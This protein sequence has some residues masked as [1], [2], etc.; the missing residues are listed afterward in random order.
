MRRTIF[1]LLVLILLAPLFFSAVKIDL[2][3]N[4]DRPLG[5]A[6][7]EPKKPAISI[8]NIFNG[9]FQNEFEKYFNYNLRGRAT[10]SR[11]Y[12]QIIYGLFKSTT[13]NILLT[14]KDGYLFEAG[15][16]LTYLD[17][18]AENQKQNL[19]DKMVTLA[20]LQKT[21]ERMGKYL[22]VIITPSKAS[23]YPEHLPNDYHKYAMLKNGGGGGIHKI[24]MNILFPAPVILTLNILIIMMSFLSLKKME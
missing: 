10:M 23:I 11:I 20:S 19:Y 18:P 14:G 22:F 21:L 16:P 13:N 2:I 3:I 1:I 9:N 6:Y 17:E 24:I 12:N 5:G 7:E 15:Y 8:A 4:I